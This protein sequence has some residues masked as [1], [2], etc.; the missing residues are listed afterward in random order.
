MKRGRFCFLFKIQMQILKNNEKFVAFMVCCRNAE[1]DYCSYKAVSLAIGNCTIINF[2]AA[3]PL[4][5]RSLLFRNTATAKNAML[6][7]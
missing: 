2:K 6:N 1:G 5:T 4:P 3:N 7:S